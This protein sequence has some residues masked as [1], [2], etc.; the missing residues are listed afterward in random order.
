MSYQDSS[1]RRVPLQLGTDCPRTERPERRNPIQILTIPEP[2]DV[3]VEKYCQWQQGHVSRVDHKA[4]YDK[5][6]E[7]LLAEGISLEQVYKDQDISFL[8]EK[9]IGKGFARHFV[10]NIERWI[11]EHESEQ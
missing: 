10:E 1:I 2:R 7:I 8:T 6:G 11:Q 3:A 9:K 4:Q 5:I